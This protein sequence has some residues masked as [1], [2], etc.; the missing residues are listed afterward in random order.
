MRQL[1]QVSSEVFLPS[2]MCVSVINNRQGTDGNDTTDASRRDT[3]SFS[4]SVC[5]CESVILCGHSAPADMD[6]P[7]P[8]AQGSCGVP[9]PLLGMTKRPDTSPS[10]SSSIGLF[11]QITLSSQD[12]SRFP[13]NCKEHR[14]FLCPLV[15]GPP[16]DNTLRHLVYLSQLRENTGLLPLMKFCALFG[17]YYFF[18][19][20]LSS[21][22]SPPRTPRDIQSSCLVRLLW[23]VTAAPTVLVLRDLDS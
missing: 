5:S 20:T 4:H 6:V 14:E 7:S 22:R 21:S 15:T 19:N 10:H 2:N 11:A 13:E 16:A 9:L 3:E 18:P 1:E 12:S 23:A 8:G 17:F